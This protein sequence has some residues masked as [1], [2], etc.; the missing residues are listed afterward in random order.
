[1]GKNSSNTKSATSAKRMTALRQRAQK[2]GKKRLELTVEGTSLDLIDKLVEFY[3]VSGRAEVVQGLLKKPLVE[4]IESMQIFQKEKHNTFGNTELPEQAEEALKVAKAIMWS[5]LINGVSGE[6][7]E[8][9]KELQIKLD[10][11]E[12]K[13]QQQ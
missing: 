13:E 9:L 5:G 7:Y 3:G 11:E 1:M 2:S 4:A 12:Q 10:L 6:A 8:A